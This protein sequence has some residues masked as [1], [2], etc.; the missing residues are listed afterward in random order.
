MKKSFFI[1]LFSLISFSLLYAQNNNA[2]ELITQYGYVFPTNK[3]LN[4]TNTGKP[5]DRVKS[6]AARYIIHT[7]GS[8]DWH[9]MYNYIEYGFGAYFASFNEPK[10]LGNAMAIYSFVYSPIVSWGK[11]TL[12]NDL[13][14]GLSY[15]QKHWSLNNV[16]NISIGSHLNCFIQE[17]F[18]L[19]YKIS[20]HF[21]LA[22]GVNVSHISNGA[23]KRP[24]KGINSL[25]SQLNLRYNFYDT[26]INY[27]K[28]KPQFKKGYDFVLSAFG[29]FYH[30]YAEMHQYALTDARRYHNRTF[31]AFG[32]TTIAYKRLSF[33]N[34]LGLGFNWGYDDLA[35]NY[36]KT[37]NNE[38]ISTTTPFSHRLNLT[39]F[40]SYE[41]KIN[42]FSALAEI[43]YYL[44]RQTSEQSTSNFFQR[45]GLRYNI[46]DN[47]FLT[48]A[49]RA[50]NLSVAHYIEW[51]IGYRFKLLSQN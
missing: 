38:L 31:Y 4:G 15:V 36:F 7:D 41:Y 47:L 19:D 43:G 11:F 33:K 28:D 6:M 12:K 18:L 2:L 46:F 20:N 25:S 50:S 3:F 10:H 32:L 21:Q 5:V 26:E 24:N 42:H 17:G 27:I 34:N 29:G 14:I 9:Q 49:I 30:D 13:V 39:C 8:K 48:T 44:I 22:L 40:L 35:D 37:E 23:T 1:F 45:V 51:G 16:E